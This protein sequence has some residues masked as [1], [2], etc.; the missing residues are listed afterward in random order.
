MARKPLRRA[1]KIEVF[2]DAERWRLLREYR[3]EAIKI[4]E[5]LERFHLTSM[6]HG[7]IARGDVTQESDIDV[8]I[9]E[10]PSSF[11]VEN[12]LEMAGISFCRRVI[13]Q[14]TPAYAAKAYVEINEKTSVSFPLMKMR[15]VE[16][17]FYRFGGEATLPMLKKGERV[18]GVDKRLMLI[19]PTDKGHIE[20]SIIGREAEAAQTLGVSVETVLDRVRAL[21]R[22]DQIGRTGVFIE[23]EIRENETFEMAL[24][25]LADKNPAVR[26]RLKALK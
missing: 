26:R 16:R 5:A 3:S 18:K 17:E 24:K 25:R 7:S 19:E 1:E 11:K 8:F 22:R 23:K 13:V 14:A 2:Y 6:V 20:S 10:A 15:T 9:P 12:A 21:L 4:M